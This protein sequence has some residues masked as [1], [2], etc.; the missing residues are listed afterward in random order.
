VD[1][2]VA[3]LSGGQRQ[4]IAVARSVYTDAR[5]LLL[6][7]PLGA[8]EAKEDALILNLVCDRVRVR[9]FGGGGARGGRR[10][11][12]PR[13]GPSVGGGA[14]RGRRRRDLRLRPELLDG[15]RPAAYVSYPVV[16][17]HEWAGR[18]RLAGPDV[19]DLAP[20]DPT[21]SLNPGK[22]GPGGP[23]S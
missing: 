17:G 10:Q 13:A 2:E 19:H 5:V 12:R 15:R 22:R 18:V 6:D 9:A 14:G 8:M 4:A 23:E 7:E 20:G 16:P 11:G 1:V 21:V 3:K